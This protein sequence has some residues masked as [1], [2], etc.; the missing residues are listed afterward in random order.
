MMHTLPYVLSSRV[1][2]ARNLRHCR[3]PHVASRQERQ[4]VLDQVHDAVVTHPRLRQADLV[5]IDALHP[6]DRRVLEEEGLISHR[7]AS[8]GEQRLAI[9]LN[10]HKVSLLVNEEDHLRIQAFQPGLELKRAWKAA[11]TIENC[12]QETLDFAYS[13]Q[14]G[15]L[16]T[17]P[18]NAGSG[19]RASAMLFV[20]GLIVSKQ[21][22]PLMTHCLSAG[23][24]VRGT[25]GEGSRSQ[26]Y[27][28]QISNQRPAEPRI[29]TLLDDLEQTC[30]MLVN[31]ERQARRALLASNGTTALRQQI[32]RAK[33]QLLTLPQIDLETGTKLLALCRLGVSWGLPFRSTSKRRWSGTTQQRDFARIDALMLRIQPAHIMQYHRRHHQRTHGSESSLSLEND[34]TLRARLI[35]SVMK[36]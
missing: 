17:C 20:P 12:L 30:Q 16:T 2:I 24:T 1:R 10:T 25:S 3:F 35:R 23:Y 18:T 29:H 31:R 4:V 28:L 6:L 9:L 15:Y 34:A 19:I 26:G 32:L 22:L 33:Q 8:Q 36:A 27:F 21:I 14:Y 5:P 13:Q 11:R 7:F